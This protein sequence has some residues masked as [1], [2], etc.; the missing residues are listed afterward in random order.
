MDEFGYLSVLL[1]I[2]I[3]LAV[4]Q[5]LTG[6]RGL[7]LRR[8]RVRRYWVPI[9]WSGIMLGILTQTWW[10]MFGLRSRREWTFGE[11]AAVLLHTVLTYLA[12]ALVLPDFDAESVDLREH[13]FAHRGWFFTLLLLT[14]AASLAKSLALFGRLPDAT[15]VAFHAGYA[16]MAV[17]ALSTARPRVHEALAVVSGAVFV[18]YV[19][20]LF[21]R[22]R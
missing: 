2:I 10:A 17:V 7:M 6:V 21:T 1:S 16:T 22:L 3:G 8:T 20:L 5:V 12:A 13:Y 19:A 18:L 15:D 4:T 14:T 9:A 11:F